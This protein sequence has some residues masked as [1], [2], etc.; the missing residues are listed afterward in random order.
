[1]ANVY[2]LDIGSLPTVASNTKTQLQIPK[3]G[4]IFGLMLQFSAAGAPLTDLQLVNDVSLIRVV[5]DG[6]EIHSISGKNLIIWMNREFG[7]YANG[8]VLQT[9][10]ANGVLFIPFANMAYSDYLNQSASA[11]GT[12]DIQNLFLEVT[13]G[14]LITATACAVSVMNDVVQA[15][16]TQY[17]SFTTFP[18]TLIAGENEIQQLP[19]EPDVTVLNYQIVNSNVGISLDKSQILVNS[20]PF[21]Q[22]PKVIARVK[23]AI[24]KRLTQIPCTG[25]VA[26]LTALD[27]T[28][29]DFNP[30]RDLASGLSL[31]GVV[32][33]RL[34]L[35]YTGA[36]GAVDIVRCS[37][38]NHAY[39]A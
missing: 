29:L 21:V 17:L 28:F 7:A 27:A 22:L 1:M 26:A 8:N 4:R 11:L 6:Q 18:Q 23:E 12:K 2:Q 34:K 20:T 36:P 10:A 38:R 9:A 15:N 24:T 13:F 3:Y 39:K 16:W 14:A 32:D 25:S 19:K 33:Q 30:T 35:T 5:A 31:N 37:L